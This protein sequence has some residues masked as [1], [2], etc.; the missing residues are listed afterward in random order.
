MKKKGL[1]LMESTLKIIIA[2]ICIILLVGLL[3]ALLSS[4][5]KDRLTDEQKLEL[6]RESLAQI[7][8]GMDEAQQKGTGGAIIYGPRDFLIV[9]WPQYLKLLGK[10]Y[11]PDKCISQGW[12]NCLCICS[13][14]GWDS[15]WALKDSCNVFGECIESKEV[16]LPADSLGMTTSAIYIDDDFILLDIEYYGNKYIIKEK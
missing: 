13:P 1:F 3:Y 4:F 6:A 11:I 16:E 12:G 10:I 7:K 8:I 5:T 9:N 2:V 14:K 15:K